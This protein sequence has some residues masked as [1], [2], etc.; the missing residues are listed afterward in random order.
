MPLPNIAL[1]WLAI[2]SAHESQS[3]LTYFLAA[4]KSR[5]PLSA[6]ALVVSARCVTLF[7]LS[8]LVNA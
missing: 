5:V 1:N 7:A 3:V 6:S 8:L 4:L 2:T